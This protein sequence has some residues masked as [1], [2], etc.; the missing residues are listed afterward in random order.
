MTPYPEALKNEIFQ[1]YKIL[2]FVQIDAN[3]LKETAS[4]VKSGELEGFES[5]GVIIAMSALIQALDELIA[6]TTPPDIL[7]SEWD[8]AIEIHRQT[9]EILKRWWD[10]E[11]NST[12]V[13]DEISA[14]LDE[15]ETLMGDIDKELSNNFHFDP[16]ELKQVRDD[17]IESINVIFETPTPTP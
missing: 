4:R 17:A 10:K 14:P 9:R 2:L 3:L 11:I 1:I 7:K 12:N 15:I 8:Q 13:L 5:L 16:A 6:E